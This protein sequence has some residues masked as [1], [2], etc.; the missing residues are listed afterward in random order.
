MH[1]TCLSYKKPDTNIVAACKQSQDQSKQ[2]EAKKCL[3]D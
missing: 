1:K 2:N 3:Q